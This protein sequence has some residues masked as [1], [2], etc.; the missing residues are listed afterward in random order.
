MKT[1]FALL[2]ILISV[3]LNAQLFTGSKKIEYK[4]ELGIKSFLK[5]EFNEL[6]QSDIS[7]ELAI[8]KNT[9]HAKH[10]QYHVL[11]Q[12]I[13][14]YNHTIKVSVDNNFDI[15]AIK[16][17]SEYLDLLEN[18]PS[19]VEILKFNKLDINQIVL[20]KWGDVNLVK[21]KQFQIYFENNI[22]QI[23][24]QLNAWNQSLDESILVD[25]NGRII[26]EINY[27]RQLLKDTIVSAKVFKPDPLTT[28][29]KTYG[30][31]YIDNSDANDSWMNGAYF[32]VN[33]PSTFDNASNTFY[34]ENKFVKID[35]FESPNIAPTTS[36]SPNFIYDRS[37][38]GFE[39]C[40]IVYHITQ[41]Q[42]YI[43]SIGYDTLLKDG[44]TADAHGQFGADNSVFMRNGGS[45][46]LSFGTGGVDDAEDADVI[47]HEFCHGISWSANANDNFSNERSG[48]DEGLADYFA[49]SYS[50]Q[51]N[52]FNWQNMFSWD[53]HNPFW[54][55]RIANT[56]DNYGNTSDIYKLGE[57]WNSAMSTMSTNLG[58]YITDKLMLESLHFFTNN[59]TLPEAAMYILKSDTLLYNGINV[60]TICA[61]FQ[62]RNI[63]GSNCMPVSVNAIPKNDFAK[64]ANTIGF[65][66]NEQSLI[67]TFNTPQNGNY[68]ITDM[69]GK[70][71]LNQPF[72]STKNIKISP[73]QFQSGIYLLTIKIGSETQT[74]KI[75]KW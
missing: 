47:I 26:K 35:D 9:K 59:T 16:K 8:Y 39:E 24:L 67:I 15:I 49:T 72:S 23:V 56:T 27:A 41:F 4:N 55:G 20:Q 64:I 18:Y 28:L 61:N 25:I 32:T 50:R 12:N 19:E 60:P 52:T 57:I 22:P 37:Q 43:A 69:T 63:L 33:I 7:L 70:I 75:A 38:A 71:M 73:N 17:E 48:L 46:T 5:A 14:I 44:I 31:I 51:L 53:G 10:Y 40:N 3:Q 1:L 68:S 11:Y 65:A 62:A 13:P 21:S 42:D 54:I 66:K 58:N 2:V 29:N 36:S 30:G 34:L 74:I 6:N 45:P